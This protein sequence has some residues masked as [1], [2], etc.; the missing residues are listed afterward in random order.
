MD[1]EAAKDLAVI[2]DHFKELADLHMMKESLRSIYRV[3]DN[4]L[5]TELS[6]EK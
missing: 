1:A 3:A 5:E 2:K 6:L 4:P